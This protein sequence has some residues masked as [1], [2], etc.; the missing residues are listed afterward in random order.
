MQPQPIIPVLQRHN[1]DFHPVV[2]FDPRTDK[3]LLMDFTEKNTSLT[4][5]I[6]EN[7]EKFCAYIENKL[8]AAH[9]L[10][11]IG[12][13]NELRTIYSR[14]K[15]FDTI[16][17]TVL[18]GRLTGVD[19]PRRL[20]I[21]VDIWGRAG[22]PV[23]AFMG[24]MIHSFAFNKQPG[25]YGAT[26]IL[27]HQLEGISFYSLY[28]HISLRDIEKIYPGQYVTRGEIIAHFGEPAENGYWPPHLHIQLILDMELKEGDYPGVCKFSERE[29]YLSNCPDP[30]LVLKLQQFL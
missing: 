5:D 20:H 16:N 7:N 18:A 13:Y 8:N 19:E 17:S 22:T 11:G 6:F 24:G 25:D 27:L 12:G 9:S 3:I 2:P 28:G 15:L 14:S 23:Y 29:K 4:P 30:E 21:G 26:L 10:Y 1:H